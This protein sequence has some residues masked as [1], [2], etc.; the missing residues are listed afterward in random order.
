MQEEKAMSYTRQ[1]TFPYLC[2]SLFPHHEV[3][4][5]YLRGV[6]R[7]LCKKISSTSGS[8]SNLL[9]FLFSCF[10]SCFVV[11]VVIDWVWFFLLLL[12]MIIFFCFGRITMF[13]RELLV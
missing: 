10:D 13:F 3:Y 12:L 8:V 6:F 2:P 7:L 4:F 1:E 9:C 5:M 11:V